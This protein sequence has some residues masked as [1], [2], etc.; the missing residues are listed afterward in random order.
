MKAPLAD[1][2]IPGAM[3]EQT[4]SS[5]N[6]LFA[7]ATDR[8]IFVVDSSLGTHSLL[9]V[10]AEFWYGICFGCDDSCIIA[11]CVDGGSK[12]V[13][14]YRIADSVT[15]FRASLQ[16]LTVGSGRILFAAASKIYLTVLEGHKRNI[17]YVFDYATGARQQS[18][19]YVYPVAQLYVPDPVMLLM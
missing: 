6:T 14:V 16:F 9:S 7:M 15:M 17:V 8:E 3:P 18:N 2:S 12:D 19:V 4:S 10:T 5:N 1:D 11:L 13:G